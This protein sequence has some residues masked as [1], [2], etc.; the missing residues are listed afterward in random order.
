[1]LD[2]VDFPVAQILVVADRLTLSTMEAIRPY[3]DRIQV[4]HTNVGD[5]GLARNFGTKVGAGEHIA[6]STATTLLATR[7]SIRRS[8]SHRRMQGTSVIRIL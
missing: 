3:Q 7:G 2:A 4:V 6:F 1:M 8:L 5:L